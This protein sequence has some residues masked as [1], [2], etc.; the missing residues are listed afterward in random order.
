MCVCVWM[1]VKLGSNSEGGE[2]EWL[3]AAMIKT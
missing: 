1:A 3:A 2:Y